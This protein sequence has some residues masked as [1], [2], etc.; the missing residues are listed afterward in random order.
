VGSDDPVEVIW[1]AIEAMICRARA[2]LFYKTRRIGIVC[3][4]L[5]GKVYVKS[6][7]QYSR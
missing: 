6:Q 3:Q 1:K 2:K 7:C 5:K 4:E